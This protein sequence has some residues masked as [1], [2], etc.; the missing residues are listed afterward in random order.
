M[1]A[2]F[3]VTVHHNPACGTSRDALALIREAGTEPI[4]AGIRSECGVVS[5]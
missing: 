3:P 4:D 2:S 1:S 5:A